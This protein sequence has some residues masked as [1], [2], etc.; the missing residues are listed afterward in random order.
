MAKH[1][2]C[3][4]DLCK[5]LNEAKSCDGKP[6]FEGNSPVKHTFNK[7]AKSSGHSYTMMGWVKFVAGGGSW[8]NVWHL[9]PKDRDQPRNP[10][11]FLN[12]SGRYLHSCFTD[13][14]MKNGNMARNSSFRIS[15]NKWY[16]VT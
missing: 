10:A 14:K 13:E 7:L 4:E 15:W 1:A 11:L 9:S 8:A 16:H 6:T 3:S 5:H 2:D 12:M